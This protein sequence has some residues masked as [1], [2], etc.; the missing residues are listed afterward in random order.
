MFLNIVWKEEQLQH[1]EDDDAQQMVGRPQREFFDAVDEVLKAFL[2]VAAE[3]LPERGL[4][5]DGVV[6]ALHL[7][8]FDL[9]GRE[10]DEAVVAVEIGGVHV[11]LILCVR[12]GVLEIDDVAH[13]AG[14]LQQVLPAQGQAGR[15]ALGDQT[16]RRV[17]QRGGILPVIVGLQIHDADHAAADL[18]S[19]AEHDR[20]ASAVLVTDSEALARAVADELERQIPLLERAEIARVSI[21]GNGKIIVA[22]DL[23]EAVD[24]AN[25]IAP[26]HLELCVDNPFDWLD[27]IRHAGSVFLGRFCPEALG[28]YFAGPDH[29]LPTGGTARFYSVLNVE[30]FM[31]RTSFISYTQPALQNVSDDI[32]RLAEAEG[33]QALSSL[34]EAYLMT[35]L[36]HSFY[37]LDFYKSLLYYGEST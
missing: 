12:Q 22:D 2:K 26:E 27:R 7:L 20:M 6:Q 29:I 37:T 17:H 31:K 11:D 19:Q 23:S 10:A 1:D 36:E 9:H 13:G 24:I 28:D 5:D 34:T 15:D 33:L 4:F 35:Q 18:L 21:D 32:V 8:Q 3:A 25:E 16:F 14:L 30:T